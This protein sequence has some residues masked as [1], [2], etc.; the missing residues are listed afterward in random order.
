VWPKH[1]AQLTVVNLDSRTT[2]QILHSAHAVP[3]DRNGCR[4][5]NTALDRALPRNIPDPANIHFDG[6]PMPTTGVERM[7][8]CWYIGNRLAASAL[9]GSTSGRHIART[10]NALPP[11]WPAPQPQPSLP[12][13]EEVDRHDGVQLVVHTRGGDVEVIARL[14]A[15]NGQ[16]TVSTGTHG[17]LVEPELATALAEATG[18]PFIDGYPAN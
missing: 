13:C 6:L 14:A 7:S 16:R 12:S 1:G 10:V 9:L 4:A 15:C 8:V 2:L 11:K 3:V 5:T 18:I 17:V